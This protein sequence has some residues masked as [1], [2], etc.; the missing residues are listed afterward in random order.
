[1]GDP[2][3]E[4]IISAQKTMGVTDNGF[5]PSSLTIA[6]GDTVTFSWFGNNTNAHKVVLN[7]VPNGT[8]PSQI[9]GSFKVAF[10]SLGTF[11]VIDGD[12]PANTGSITVLQH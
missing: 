9:T 3:G 8:S 1:M 6:L 11:K 2:S 4:G 10:T 7:G 5:S 12:K